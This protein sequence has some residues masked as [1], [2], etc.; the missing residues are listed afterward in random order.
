MAYWVTMVGIQERSAHIM[1]DETTR[2]YLQS[3]NRHMTLCQRRYPQNQWSSTA[4]QM[5]VRYKP[6]YQ[7][8]MV[9]T[10]HLGKDTSD[11]LDTLAWLSRCNLRYV[12][13]VDPKFFIL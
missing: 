5:G 12:F 9:R 4:W 10:K 6:F 11:A 2:K 7:R 1:N 8:R 3:I 13:K